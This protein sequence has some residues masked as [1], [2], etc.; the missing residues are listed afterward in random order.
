MNF[1]K[2]IKILNKKKLFLQPQNVDVIIFDNHGSQF[3]KKC[4][5]NL[6]V[7]VLKNRIDEIF[8]KL[9]NGEG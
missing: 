9:I 3:L 4:L 7:V 5:I 8:S 6:R 2:G 1:F